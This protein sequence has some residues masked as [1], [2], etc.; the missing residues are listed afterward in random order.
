MQ[1]KIKSRNTP[2]LPNNNPKYAKPKR[3]RINVHIKNAIPNHQKEIPKTA[4]S[5][6]SSQV[7]GEKQKDSVKSNTFH[8][9]KNKPKK[10]IPSEM[11]KHLCFS[12]FIFYSP[13]LII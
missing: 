4:N 1:S 9:E 11:G 8:A 13:L 6:K 2:T 7:A 10:L 5:E 3:A 12:G